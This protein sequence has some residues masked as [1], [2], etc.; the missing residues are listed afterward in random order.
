M[1]PYN[2]TNYNLAKNL[3]KNMTLQERKLWY[4]FLKSHSF[5]FYRQKPI[6]NYIA[7]FYCAKAHLVIEI[8]G[9][10]HYEDKQVIKDE[11][12]T[13]QLKEIGLTVIRFTNTDIDKHFESVCNYI[14]YAINE[15]TQCN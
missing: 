15:L 7:D 2:K 13:E 11:F 3:R 9:G 12:R 4:L 6:L 14:N 8:D 1:K 5:K 10:G